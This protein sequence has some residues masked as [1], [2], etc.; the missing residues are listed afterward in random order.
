[1]DLNT[2]NEHGPTTPL[3]RMP[4]HESKVGPIVG[5]IIVIIVL[6]IGALYFWGERLNKT[7]S[8]SSQS[9]SAEV[10]DPAVGALEKQSTSD[11]LS[12]IEQD[13]NAT[14]IDGLDADFQQAAVVE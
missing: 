12:S 13:L 11:E 8:D 4:E 3:P 10:G 14:A 2:Q 6:V 1:M 7:E 5:I 9:I